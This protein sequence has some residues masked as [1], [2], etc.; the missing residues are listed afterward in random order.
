M[1]ADLINAGASRS[2][3]LCKESIQP[4]RAAR[5]QQEML[6]GRLGRRDLVQIGQGLDLVAIQGMAQLAI[7]QRIGARIPDQLVALD[8]SVIRILWKGD[9]REEQRIDDRQTVHCERA[10]SFAQARQIMGDY[11][12]ANEEA[13]PCGEA[14]EGGYRFMRVEIALQDHPLI[15]VGPPRRNFTERAS[16]IG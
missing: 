8:E 12:V 3:N 7:P 13:G 2:S 6:A 5:S 14:I 10:Q 11:I 16:S 1:R 15:G 9:R 4:A